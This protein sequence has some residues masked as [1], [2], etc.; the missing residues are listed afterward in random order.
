MVIEVERLIPIKRKGDYRMDLA[1]KA[2]KKLMEAEDEAGILGEINVK[3]FMRKQKGFTAYFSHKGSDYV[4]F[5]DKSVFQI[6][7]EEN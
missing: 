1:Q 6:N 3:E 4:H 7:N 2:Y 5:N